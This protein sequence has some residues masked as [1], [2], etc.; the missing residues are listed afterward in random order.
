MIWRGLWWRLLLLLQR[1]LELM[2]LVWVMLLLLKLMLVER[3]QVVV[4]HPA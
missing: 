1:R 3:V 2:H 4:V